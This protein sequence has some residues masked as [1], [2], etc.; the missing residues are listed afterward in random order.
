MEK[1]HINNG[2]KWAISCGNVV[3][4]TLAIENGDVP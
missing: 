4:I 1:K 2:S 3:F